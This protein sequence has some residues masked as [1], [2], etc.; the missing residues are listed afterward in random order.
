M[1][2]AWINEYKSKDFLDAFESAAI[3]VNDN[4]AYCLLSVSESNIQIIFP[5]T[6]KVLTDDLSEQVRSALSQLVELNAIVK[7]N[8]VMGDPYECQLSMIYIKPKFLELHYVGT[9]ANFSC[10]ANFTYA[11]G[12]WQF[13]DWG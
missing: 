10:S 3:Q 5:D 12:V 2:D 9:E 7:E 11:N 6:N 13:D 8:T 1:S 4:F